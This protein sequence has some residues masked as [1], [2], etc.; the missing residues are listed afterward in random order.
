MDEEA[1]Y[2]L[3][4]DGRLGGAHVDTFEQEPYVGPLASLPNVLLTSHIGSYAAECRA[5]ME[6]EAVENLL[7]FFGEPQGT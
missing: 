6:L 4:Q 7:R 5:M 3:L 2:E 1:L